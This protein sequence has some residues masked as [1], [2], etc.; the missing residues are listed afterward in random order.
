MLHDAIIVGGG[1]AGLAAAL[2]LARA[3]RKVLVL[4]AGLPR[5]RF[6]AHSH[7]VLGHDGKPGSQLL[8]EA[9]QQLAVYPSAQMVGGT[10]TRAEARDGSFGVELDG[11]ARWFTG[12]RLLLAG[13]V[14]DVLPDLPG[15]RERWGSS[16]FHCPYCHGYEVGGG[17]IG[18]LGVSAMA[19]HQA[20]LLADWGDVTLFTQRSLPVSQ[21]D[22]AAL[23]RR[24]VRIEPVPVVALEGPAP[25]LDNVVLEDGRRVPLKALLVGTQ[26]RMASPLAETLGCAFDETPLGAIVRTDAWKLSSVP[27][28]Y[29]AGDM[30]RAPHSITFAMADGMSAGVGLHMSL[31]M[32]EAHGAA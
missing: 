4:D 3:R 30:A 15:L 27:G 8:A 18:V 14:S 26:V 7:G 9:R 5:N 13:G 29:A 21:E 6:A 16:V 24:R 17:P 31:V 12:R 25:V 19:V 32:Q 23:G 28:V 11:G 1:F 2:Q 20:L 22:A 10:V